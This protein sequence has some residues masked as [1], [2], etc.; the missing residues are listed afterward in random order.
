M[1]Y[2]S[3]QRFKQPLL[4][5][6][7]I[8]IAALVWYAFYVQILLGEPLGTRPAPDVVLVIIWFFSGIILPYAFYKSELVLELDHARLS[9]RFIPFHLNK[10]DYPISEIRN[11]ESVKIR[12]ILNFGGYGIRYGFKGKGYIIGGKKGIKVSFNSGRPV[13]FSAR[14]PEEI[15]AA[16]QKIRKERL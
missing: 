8:G 15:E 6:L 9:Y 4:W 14:N 11:I 12:P 16:F 5:L 7:I 3:S 10:H 1:Y 13:Y 2:K